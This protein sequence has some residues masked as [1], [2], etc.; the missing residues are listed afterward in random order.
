[1]R[2]ALLA[3]LVLLAAACKGRAPDGPEERRQIME[4]LT[5]SQS[6]KGRSS[7]TLKSRRA[8]LRE[9][10]KTATL[11]EPVM[12][13]YERGRKVSRVTALTGEVSTETRDVRLSSSVVLDSYEDKSRLTTTELLYDSKKAKFT[14]TADILVKRPEGTLTGKGLEAA[15]DLSEI[16]IFNQR[17]SFTGTPR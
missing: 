7:W 10:S 11:E 1:M 4:G 8:L 5:L 14:T 2:C 13:F 3:G 17:S 6:E 15:P 16:R 12:E 9:E